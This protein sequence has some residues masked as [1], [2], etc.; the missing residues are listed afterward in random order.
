MAMRG[1][2][3]LWLRYHMRGLR[4]SLLIGLAALLPVQ[5]LA[6]RAASAPQATASSG[7]IAA[8]RL[9]ETAI[10]RRWFGNDAPWYQDNIPFFDSPDAKLNQIYYYRW[11]VFRAH[12]R[13]VGAYGDV[14]TEFLPRVGWDR[15]P[16]STLNDSAIFPIYDGRWLRDRSYLNDWIRYIWTGGGD[17]RHFSESLADA[18]WQRYLV[19]GD[20]RFA[21]RFLP[22]MEQMYSLWDDHYDFKK[23][24]YWIEPLLD[25]TEY[26]ISSIDASGGKDGFTGG[27]AF[28]PSINSYMYANARAISRFAALAGDDATARRYADKAADLKAHVEQ[29]LWSPTLHHFIDRYQV[30]NKFVH[31]WEPIRGREL[32]G[33]TPWTM[34]LSDGDP[35]YA[36]AWEHVLKPDQLR[37]KYGLRTVEP[38]YQYYMRQYRYDQATGLRE[39]QWNGPVWPFQTTQVLI[40]LANL[41]NTTQQN[42]ITRSDYAALL[43]QY[44]DLHYVDGKPD[45][46]EDYDPATGKPI[47]G[48]PRSHHYYHSSYDD[49]IISGLVGIRPRADDVLEVNPLVPRDPKDPNALPWFALEHVPYHGHLIDVVYDR[50]GS[51]Y[52]RG[53][54]LRLFVDG[55]RVAH[56]PALTRL[57]ARIGQRTLPP[58][59]RTIDLAV[60]LNGQEFP[61]PSASVN[62]GDAAALGHSI[63]GRMWF[64]PQIQ[65]GWT[66][67][68][69]THATDWYAL[70]FGRPTRIAASRLYFL[71][72]GRQFAAPAAYTIQYLDHGSWRDLATHAAGPIA[73]GV[74]ADRW[75]AVTAQQFRV[76]LT[77][78]KDGRAIRLLEWKLYA[79]PPVH[80][81]VGD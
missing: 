7:S 47:V 11:K 67:Q 78:P 4:A 18:T 62:D 56:A 54:G 48:L 37:G 6:A 24:L 57:T 30:D 27:Q 35:K 36:V 29:D 46:Q 40:G 25:A 33:Y 13:S 34:R 59:P 70:D 28:R 73:N 50:D 42:V 80:R 3:K 53:A 26:T 55:R 15:V 12:I 64:F 68:G 21:T 32:V 44:T 75:T 31:Y 22:S 19:D 58:V 65:Q 49:L 76:R 14:F 17:D 81:Y 72:D 23:H 66:T 10:A 63:D 39:C 41:L 61:K 45:I 9:P 5:P 8:P 77:A 71:D 16:Y 79:A 60:R 74:D 52:H 43:S 69:S 51:H 1:R 38:S 2:S 20:A